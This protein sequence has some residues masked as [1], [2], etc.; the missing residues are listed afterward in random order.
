MAVGKGQSRI[1]EF[2][3]FRGMPSEGGEVSPA[4]AHES[5]PVFRSAFTRPVHAEIGARQLQPRFGARTVSA[6][7]SPCSLDRSGE[8]HS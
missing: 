6:Q 5:T 2:R 1:A 7:P 8:H 4:E 3:D